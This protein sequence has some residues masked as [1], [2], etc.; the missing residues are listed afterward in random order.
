MRHLLVSVVLQ[1]AVAG[2]AGQLAPLAFGMTLAASI[3]FLGPITGAA[4]NP[5]RAIDQQSLTVTCNGSCRT[6]WPP[7]SVVSWPAC[8][9]PT[10]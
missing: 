9:T 5:A 1:T 10:C 2:K 6:A 4:M 8:S 3:M 7:S